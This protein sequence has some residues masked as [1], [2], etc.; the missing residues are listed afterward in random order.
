MQ[1]LAKPLVLAVFALVLMLGTQIV[2]L[3]LYWS[4]L[5][6]EPSAKALV[7]KSEAPKPFEWGF[8]SDN[9][10]QLENELRDRLA[11]LQAREQELQTYDA[12]LQADR[13]EIEQIKEQV[14][15]MRDTLLE[16]VVK[17]ENDEVSN[18][19]RLAKTYA[20]LAPNATV[21]IFREL[22]DETVVKILFFMKSDT[23]GA[24]LQE[25]ATANG[26]IAEE[27]RRAA[28]ISDMLRLFSDT[29]TAALD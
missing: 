12:Q 6:P 20:T 21:S 29:T 3:K 28:K 1:I 26:G 7:V 9:I 8:A 24:I 10:E 14:E 5:F 2:A 4:E 25:M 16:G 17:L 18:L 11:G 23:V 27:V 22:D 19:K 13:A 15:R